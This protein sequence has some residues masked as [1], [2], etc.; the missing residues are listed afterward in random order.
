MSVNEDYIEFYG[1]R[2]KRMNK[3]YNITL[4]LKKKK[5]IKIIN[6]YDLFLILLIS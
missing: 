6:D 4:L 2:K 5:V 3:F 1:K